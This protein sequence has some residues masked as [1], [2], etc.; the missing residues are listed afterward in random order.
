MVQRH[1]IPSSTR[2]VGS[3]GHEAGSF[4]RRL[5]LL[6]PATVLVSA[7]VLPS[8][9]EPVALALLTAGFIAALGARRQP[10]PMQ[11]QDPH[12]QLMWFR[13]RNE[14]AAVLVIM[15][16][17]LRRSQLRALL[18]AFRV[19][20]SV[21][22]MKTH[23]GHEVQA[24][25]DGK[26]LLR[27]GV[28]RRIS[29]AV[30]RATFSFGWASF[31]EEGKTLEILIEYAR[32]SIRRPVDELLSP[33][34]SRLGVAED[35]LRSVSPRSQE[36]A[37][38]TAELP[39]EPG[40][41]ARRTPGR[42][43]VTGCAGFLGSHLSERLVEQGR[44]VLGVDCF[45]DYYSRAA[46]ERN[47][48]QLRDEAR[49]TLHELDLSSDDLTGLLEGVDTVFHLAAQPGVRASFGA[50]FEAYLRNNVQA[51]QRLL[52]EAAHYP[53]TVFAYASS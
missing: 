41:E 3:G 32:A 2:P 23:D 12:R 37:G 7:L 35:G 53:L 29:E 46:K 48:E 52:E 14:P 8:R 21:A 26:D 17:S 27:E 51:T 28:E 22:V 25:L 36:P 40:F 24:L 9:Y 33:D 34:A 18:S 39:G 11:V 1:A 4:P 16:S 13:R 20:D 5:L 19:T 49:F 30:P 50:G 31:P 38:Q 10:T 44:E 43:L 45:T 47:L 15:V 6:G 42:V